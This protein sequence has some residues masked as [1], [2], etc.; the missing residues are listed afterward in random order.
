VVVVGVVAKLLVTV[1]EQVTALPPPVAEPLHWL[2]VTGS[3]AVAP[4]T[5]QFTAASP[6]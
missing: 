4:V 5:V 3:A 2:M 1:A 6:A